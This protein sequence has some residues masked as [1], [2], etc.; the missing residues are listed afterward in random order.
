M[1]VTM[2]RTGAREFD[3]ID[4]RPEKSAIISRTGA[5]GP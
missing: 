5:R 4:L 1:P 3:M 2:R